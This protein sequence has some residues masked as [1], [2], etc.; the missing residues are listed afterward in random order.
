MCFFF[1]PPKFSRIINCVQHKQSNSFFF[2]IIFL[3]FKFLTCSLSNERL[4]EE[5]V[6]S[7]YAVLLVAVTICGFCVDLIYFNQ[8][9][10]YLSRILP[11]LL[12]L[13]SLEELLS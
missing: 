5:S 9:V 11:S 6:L 10:F 4:L 1:P 7:V 13:T 3:I 8:I 12:Y 2:I